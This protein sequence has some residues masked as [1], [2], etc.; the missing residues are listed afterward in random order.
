MSGLAKTI[1]AWVA[2]EDTGDWDKWKIAAFP[3][4]FVVKMPARKDAPAHAAL[5][6][7]P[8]DQF[9]NPTK[10][11]GI[12]IRSTAEMEQIATVFGVETLPEKLT[13]LCDAV[14]GEKGVV[15][16]IPVAGL[17]VIE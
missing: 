14:F 17:L 16:E 5:E 2:S 3:G 9:G 13:M 7:N 15:A 8:A 4:L 11:R 6:I 1:S 12:Y 10:R